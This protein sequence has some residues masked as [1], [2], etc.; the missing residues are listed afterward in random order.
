MEAGARGQFPIKMVGEGRDIDAHRGRG[1]SSEKL[2]HKNAIK[3][4]KRQKKVD[5]PRFSDNPKDP[6]GF[7]TTV[8]LWVGKDRTGLWYKSL[9]IVALKL[10]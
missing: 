10:P 1:V 9:K 5:P 7:P 3:H 4:E 8:H 2:S 6:P